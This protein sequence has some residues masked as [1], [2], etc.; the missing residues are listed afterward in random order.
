LTHDGVG[1]TWAKP[2]GMPPAQE[3]EPS[4]PLP[5]KPRAQQLV[6]VLGVEQ[7]SRDC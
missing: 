3:A 4:S 5:P 7:L 2:A 1:K 6:T